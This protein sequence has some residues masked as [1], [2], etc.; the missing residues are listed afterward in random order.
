MLNLQQI[1]DATF[2]MAKLPG[3]YKPED[4][5]E[6]VEEVRDT[7]DTL[8]KT[9]QKQQEE[10][11]ALG[12]ENRQL[13]KK[14][15]IL[16]QKIEEYRD[17]E[18]GI[19]NAL[20]S[21]QKLGDASVRE[22]RHK[23]EIIIRDAQMKAERLVA[24]AEEEAKSHVEELETLKQ[25]VTDFRS[26]ILEMYKQH[27][28]MITSLPIKR[29]EPSEEPAAEERI[30]QEEKEDSVPEPVLFDDTEIAGKDEAYTYET[31]SPAKEDVSGNYEEEKPSFNP[32]HPFGDS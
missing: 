32:A 21:A 10:I 13:Q 1:T 11:A 15:E 2:R 29:D 25:A 8:T 28:T 5:D 9:T 23:A 22:D 24:S 16:A 31:V 6:F 7:V 14:M 12:Q 3:G 20:V 17:E 19:K 27:L 26:Q 4:V 18:D 30:P